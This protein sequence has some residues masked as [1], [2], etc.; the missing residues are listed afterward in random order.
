MINQQVA[1]CALV[2]PDGRVLVTK[3]PKFKTM[4]NLWEFPGGKVEDGELP[5][6]AIVRELSEELC[7]QTSSSCLAPVTFV[8][9]HYQKLNIILF[10]F[11]CRKWEGFIRPLEGQQIS[12]VTKSDLRSY[13]MPEA[14]SYLI[15]ILRNWV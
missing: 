1:V 4:P 9:H 2:D 10:L 12:W 11:I 3:R 5:D 14:N 7:I 8:I 15:A 6:Q 13:K